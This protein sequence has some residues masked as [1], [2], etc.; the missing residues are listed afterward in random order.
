M[1]RTTKAAIAIVAVMIL[2]IVCLA[3]YGYFSGAWVEN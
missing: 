3:L 1:D 2:F